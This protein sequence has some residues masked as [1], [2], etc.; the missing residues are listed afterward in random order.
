M[1]RVQSK[2]K[3]SQFIN[4]KDDAASRIGHTINI[5][6]CVKTSHQFVFAYSIPMY[7]HM[8]H[9]TRPILAWGH[10]RQYENIPLLQNNINSKKLRAGG[11][12]EALEAFNI[13]KKASC[14]K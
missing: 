4:A 11:R 13:L 2:S 1:L 5:Y 14:S 3:C 12:S 10:T 8:L 6:K 9:S 7:I